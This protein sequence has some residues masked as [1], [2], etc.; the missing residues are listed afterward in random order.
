M[1]RYW[2]REGKLIKSSPRSGEGE[3][4]GILTLIAS[5][6]GRKKNSFSISCNLEKGGYISPY[7]L[8]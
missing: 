8:I 6:G 4:E 2:V 1:L 7:P 5:L 3:R